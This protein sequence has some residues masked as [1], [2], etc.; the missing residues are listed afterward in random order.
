MTRPLQVPGAPVEP[1]TTIVAR[2]VGEAR[3]DLGTALASTARRVD[4]TPADRRGAVADLLHAAVDL[5]LLSSFLDA[6][7]TYATTK[8][9]PWPGTGYD[10]AADDPHLIARFGRFVAAVS[11]LEALVDE[12]TTEAERGS[13]GAVRAAAIARHHGVSVGRTFVS[14]TIELL[15]ASA[16]SI[17]HGF[18]VRWRDVLEHARRHPPQTS[19]D[20]IAG[21]D[22]AFAGP[23]AAASPL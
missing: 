6:A 7:T 1:L 21:G 18:D 16:T 23:K 2:I 10:R 3:D 4:A 5:G 12:A 11:A 15:G 14:G 22:L 17:R 20:G 13:A 19:L 8:T 9:R